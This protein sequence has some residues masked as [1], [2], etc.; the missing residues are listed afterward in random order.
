MAQQQLVQYNLGRELIPYL[1]GNAAAQFGQWVVNYARN[2]PG[3]IARFTNDAVNWLRDNGVGEQ[4]WALAQSMRER[5][6]D[7]GPFEAF[8]GGVGAIAG[9]GVGGPAG[10]I[11]N[12]GALAAIGRWGDQRGNNPR[13]VAMDSQGEL[14]DLGQLIPTNTMNNAGG[15]GGNGGGTRRPAEGPPDGEP[16]AQ[17]QAIGPGGSN[18]PSKETPISPYP[19]LSY[20]LQETHTTILPWSGWLSVVNLTKTT[21]AQLAIRMN[22]PYDFLSLTTQPTPGNRELWASKGFGVTMVGSR[23]ENVNQT[24]PK[25]LAAN[26]TATTERPQ[27]LHY[28]AQIYQRYTVLGCEWEVIVH[29]PTE[30]TEYMQYAATTAGV[31]PPELV[32]APA[33]TMVKATN[34]DLLCG[35]Q[36]DSYSDTEAASGNIMPKTLYA[37]VL[38]FKNIQWYRIEDRGKTTIIS[39]KCYPGMIKR[40]IVNDGDVKT[41]SATNSTDGTIPTLPNLKELL[42]LNFWAHPLGNTEAS[43]G[44]QAMSYA[45]NM[46]INV[47]YIVQFKDLREQARYPNT[48][49][50]TLDLIQTLNETTTAQGTA[51]AAW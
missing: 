43:S 24:F 18:A 26:S 39:G 15:N 19:S 10:A 16:T 32:T 44:P 38:G 41:W 49:N 40:N 17:R 30:H 5:V 47:K 23:G 45:A 25:E 8:L 27:W 2:N 42:T 3:D 50:T 7:I 12:G 51:H 37:E 28:W 22:T 29:N 6:Q 31:G 36:Y 1:Q 13:E 35:V 21:P 9:A 14:P 20:G 48:L 11:A 34:G 46:Q 33:V 4:A